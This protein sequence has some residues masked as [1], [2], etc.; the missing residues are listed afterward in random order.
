MHAI[1]THV[2][3]GKKRN[4]FFNHSYASYNQV[5]SKAD[6]YRVWDDYNVGDKVVL[7]ILRGN[8]NVELPIVL[9][10]RSS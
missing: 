10:E 6:L 4:V 9:E 3:Y 5:K 2:R 7:K 1:G 8:E